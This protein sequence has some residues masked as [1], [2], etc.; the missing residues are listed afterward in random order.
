MLEKGQI[1]VRTD[2]SFE[3]KA[4]GSVGRFVN[5]AIRGLMVIALF[6]GSCLLLMASAHTGDGAVI[7][8]VFRV[9]GFV[10]YAV[11]I[12]FAYRVYRNMKKG[13]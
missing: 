4:L 7:T 3:E 2:F 9:M 6:I 13:K 5:Y 1:R 12:F 8:T 10:G 11:S